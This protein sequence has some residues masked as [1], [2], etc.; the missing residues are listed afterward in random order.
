MGWI[1]C[2]LGLHDWVVSDWM[3]HETIRNN[4]TTTVYRADRYTCSRCRISE[5]A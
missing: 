1:L 5:P 2:Q 4:K 3:Q